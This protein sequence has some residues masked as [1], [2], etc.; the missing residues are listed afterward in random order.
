MNNKTFNT[1]KKLSGNNKKRKLPNFVINNNTI[2]NNKDK[3]N[4]LGKVFEKVHKQNNVI[5]RE[6]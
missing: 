6:Q 1:L 5:Q 3:L 4:L 2:T